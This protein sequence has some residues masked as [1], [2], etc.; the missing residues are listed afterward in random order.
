MLGPPGAGK[1]TQSKMIAEKFG[2]PHISTGDIFR[3]AIREKTPLGE[4][5]GEYLDKGLLVP[6]VI[7]QQ[8]VE[9]RLNLPDCEK[10]FVLDGFPRTME[11]VQSLCKYMDNKGIKLDYVVNIDVD[12]EKLIERF[13]GR[14]MCQSCG[15]S[16]HIAY[17]P[18]K[19][20]DICDKCG[21]KLIIRRDDQ[22][23]TVKKRLE[24]Y[25]ESTAPLIDFY[26]EQDVLVDIDGSKSID[27][28][29][30]DITNR[31]RGEYK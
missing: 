12:K 24:V 29:F 23:E 19:A 8:I 9:E 22:I 5:A 11:Q 16:Y 2:V 7:V 14:R 15:A 1:G 6:D 28:V 31:L 18:P 17:N 27:E 20:A 3:K 25:E 13:T 26:K 10:G 4:K 21:G 30:Q